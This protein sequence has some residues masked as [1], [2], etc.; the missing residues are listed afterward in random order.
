MFVYDNITGPLDD[1]TI[2]TENATGTKASALV[3]AG[4]A[5][6]RHRPTAPWSALTYPRPEADGAS[7]TYQVT[8]ND[9]VHERKRLINE[10]VH[11]TSD[12]GAKPAAATTPWWSRAR[13]SAPRWRCR[14]TPTASRPAG[15]PRPRP[16]SSAPVET[17]R[18]GHGR[19]LGGHPPGRHR[20]ARRGGQGHGHAE[21]ASPTAGTIPVTAKYIGDTANAGQHLGAGQPG[22]LG[23]RRPGAQGE[24]QARRGRTEGDQAGQEGQ[25]QDRRRPLRR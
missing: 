13:R 24:V 7:F 2:G 4:D 23:P 5:S 6:A 14:S 19:V 25:A 1:V 10:A 16:R 21:R 3:N 11:T 22:G 9:D 18:D 20:H 15:R 17:G 12:P 8:V